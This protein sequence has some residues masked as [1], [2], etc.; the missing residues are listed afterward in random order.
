MPDI[1]G[2]VLDARNIPLPGVTI[3]L[4][5]P[6]AAPVVQLTDGN[7]NFN[8][9]AMPAGAYKLTA[10]HGSF[11]YA[12]DKTV[13]H[14]GVAISD[15]KF[16]VTAAT[17]PPA[18]DDRYL[19]LKY[20]QYIFLGFIGLLFFVLLIW[21][22]L[23]KLRLDELESIEV[24]R[25]AITYLFTVTT[26]SMAG[27]LMLAGIMTGG[28][29]L[30]RRFALG[31]E[32]LTLMIGILG[33]IIGFYY[34]SS[35]DRGR[36]NN[37]A[38]SLRVSNVTLK[39]ASPQANKAFSVTA[40]LRGGTGPYTYSVSFAPPIARDSTVIKKSDNGKIEEKFTVRDTVK[41]GTAVR[42]IISGKDSKD[43]PFTT[44][45]DDKHRFKT[46]Q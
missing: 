13:V 5:G 28:K 45:D 23:G 11:G 21:T 30:D 35:V 15:V 18:P 3:I 19:K 34:G 10:V 40:Q 42:I 41:A 9:P 25:G 24:A 38:D 44:P 46:T 26:V 17:P 16:A 33:T 14:N 27:L 39:P 2:T 6:G 22:A 7:G 29:E 20:G 1:T 12:E 32:I 37:E 43:V 4:V 31:K 36:G 8:Y